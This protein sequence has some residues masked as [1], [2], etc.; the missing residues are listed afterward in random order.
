MRYPREFLEPIKYELN[1]IFNNETNQLILE[2]LRTGINQ[3][4]Q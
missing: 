1:D 2:N 3:L 4:S